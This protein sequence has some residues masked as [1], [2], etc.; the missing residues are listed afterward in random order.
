M[1]WLSEKQKLLDWY[2]NKLY[3]QHKVGLE[4]ELVDAMTELTE[5]TIGF[6]EYL[7]EPDIKELP[8]YH[9]YKNPRD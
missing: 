2:L 5:A 1:P 3:V 6:Q 8:I 7:D 4:I 9:R